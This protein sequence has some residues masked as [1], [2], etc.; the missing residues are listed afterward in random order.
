MGHFVT[1]KYGNQPKVLKMVSYTLLGEFVAN[2]AICLLFGQR[3]MK[4]A[5]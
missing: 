5:D 3:F 1:K 2:G 4:K